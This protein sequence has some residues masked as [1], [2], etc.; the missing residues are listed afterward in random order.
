[1]NRIPEDAGDYAQQ[2][3]ANW[4]TWDHFIFWSG[5]QYVPNEDWCLIHLDSGSQSGLIDEANQQVMVKGL[6]AV[7][8]RV[9]A[10]GKTDFEQCTIGHDLVGRMNSAMVR[11]RDSRGKLTKAFQLLHSYR[12]KLYAYPILDEDLYSELCEEE[13]D[14]AWQEY[15]CAD[16]RK[17]LKEEFGDRFDSYD[18]EK[19][20]DLYSEA[21]GGCGRYEDE[22]SCLHL[23][24]DTAIDTL[25]EQA[26]LV[27][28]ISEH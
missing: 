2:M 5:D 9:R 20:L 14:R 16:F 22:G 27:D 3:S 18:D 25:R 15:G 21:V 13:F 10:D 1:M 23:T 28:G 12:R 24:L 26:G 6:S 19:L 17:Q 8:K 7:A 11:I 4:K